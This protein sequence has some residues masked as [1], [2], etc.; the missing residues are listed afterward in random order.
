MVGYRGRIAWDTAKPDGSP[1]KLMDGT[2]L[3]A[4]G[5]RAQI[6]LREG[7]EKTYAAFLAEKAAGTLRG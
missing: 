3:A 4:L 5:W 7:I 2:L 1:R 6:G